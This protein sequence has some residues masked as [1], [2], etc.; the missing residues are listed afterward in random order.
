MQPL[1]PYFKP[2]RKHLLGAILATILVSGSS[3]AALFL[4]EQGTAALFIDRDQGALARVLILTTIIF[5]LVGVLA[6][7]QTFLSTFVGL[8]VATDMR[9]DAFHHVL[10]LPMAFQAQQ[11]VGDLMSRINHDIYV[12]QQAVGRVAAKALHIVLM[13]FLVVGYL[14]YLDWRL[15]LLSVFIVPPFVGAVLHLSKKIHHSI[16]C[17]S[18]RMAKLNS[19]LQEILTNIQTIKYFA[20][21]DREAARFREDNEEYFRLRMKQVRLSAWYQPAIALFQMF[22][23]LAVIWQSG[24]L[25]TEG[26]ISPEQLTAF[27]A[28]IGLLVNAFQQMSGLHMELQPIRV[29]VERFFDLLSQPLSLRESPHALHPRSVHGDLYFDKVSFQYSAG[30]PTVLDSIDLHISAGE[31]LALVGPS[32][33][34]K[35]TLTNLIPRLYDPTK[36]RVLLDDVD[37]RDIGIHSLRRN[38]GVVSQQPGIFSGTLRDN[39]CYARPEAT[40]KEILEAARLAHVHEFASRLPEGYDTR[41]GEQGLHL[42]AGER[43]RL[44]IARVFLLNPP[45]LILDEATAFLDTNSEQLIQDALGKLLQGRTA[46]LITHRFSSVRLAHRI[47]VLDHGRIIESGSHEKL[48]AKDGLYR[49]L[50]TQ[51][52][53]KLRSCENL[54][55]MQTT[56][57]NSLKA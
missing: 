19:T 52:H 8:R 35:T 32:G 14:F 38:I 5:S 43:Q 55:S 41:V 49:R 33:A 53:S 46:I 27:F 6:F 57:S 56:T 26:G 34:G 10:H 30:H 39:I 2:Y 29:S 18:R 37:L 40:E 15:T 42:S 9:R 3:I 44:T 24:R 7:G 20:T 22:C 47:V 31:V 45:I 17:S 50:Y 12:I 21:E 51:Q 13:P 36:G 54:P 25:V 1:L 23:F 4:I 11:Q 48:M 28:G 16:H